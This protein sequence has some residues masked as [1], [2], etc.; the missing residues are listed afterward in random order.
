M[1][2]SSSWLEPRTAGLLLLPALLIGA[3]TY[4]YLTPVPAAPVAPTPAPHTPVSRLTQQQLLQRAG[5]V[6]S[7][8]STA[9]TTADLATALALAQ[10]GARHAALTRLG[11]RLPTGGGAADLLQQLDDETDRRVFARAVALAITAADPAAAATWAIKL[12]PDLRRSMLSVVIERWTD[13]GFAP[14]VAWAAAQSGRTQVMAAEEILKRWQRQDLEAAADW[15]VEL[16]TQPDGASFSTVAP[17]LWARFDA[18]GAISWSAALPQARQPGA[19]REIA[20]ALG[21]RDPQGVGEQLL[22]LP[23]G[24]MRTEGLIWLAN[25]WAADFPT[26]A[27]SWYEAHLTE[28]AAAAPAVAGQWARRSPADATAWA[29]ALPAS[30][31]RTQAVVAGL[32]VWVDR[33]P[34]A[35]AAWVDTVADPHLR[36]AAALTT[37]RTWA[38]RDPERA[39]AWAHDQAD[40]DSPAVLAAVST[41]AQRDP[42]A[43]VDWATSI[44]DPQLR[45]DAMLGA[46]EHWLRQHRSAAID[47]LEQSSLPES[48][49]A[50]LL[51][52]D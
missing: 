10:P 5:T 9:P 12:P 42:P 51:N 36:A 16:A 17:G 3:I 41:W 33:D 38:R 29:A 43:A 6:T 50:T 8:A 47:W 26:A 24:A 40:I 44:S 48:D 4:V 15:A 20:V 34:I 21:N 19:I 49:Q 27:V 30:A 23:P 39:A 31:P 14:A 13:D 46:A 25:T 2:H 11:R 22:Q 35:A 18:P 37:V 52:N 32:L 7:R 45:R 28:T 1:P